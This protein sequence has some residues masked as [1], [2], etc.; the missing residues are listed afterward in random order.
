MAGKLTLILGGAR[1]GKS[2]HAERLAAE[3]SADVLYV[4]TAEPMDEEMRARIEAHQAQRPES[5]RT[6]E[7][8][9]EVGAAITGCDPE[10][11]VVLLDCI[12]LLA[13]NLF[14]QRAT[15]DEAAR[16]A[17]EGRLEGEIDALLRAQ[18][19]SQAH[20]I[21]VSNEVGQGIVPAYP[22]GRA[23]R[24]ALGRGNIRLAEAAD[25]VLYMV[26]GLP[27]TLKSAAD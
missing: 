5:W 14:T 8:P 24:D 15:E 6:L 16:Q 9:T 10:P 26:A 3:I 20:W 13:N 7:A 21:V 25:T 22:L 1:S 19:R 12:T 23:Y 2:S 11:E 4:A 18:Q 17:G 27:Q